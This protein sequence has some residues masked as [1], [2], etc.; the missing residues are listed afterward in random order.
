[1]TIM[2]KAK[3]PTICKYY[4]HVDLE[5][6]STETCLIDPMLIEINYSCGPGTMCGYYKQNLEKIEKVQ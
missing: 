6:G 5:N 1:M 4:R 2:R 3:S